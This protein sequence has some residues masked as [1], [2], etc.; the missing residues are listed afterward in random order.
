MHSNLLTNIYNLAFCT[1]TRWSFGVF[2]QQLID[3][4]DDA[5]DV[6]PALDNFLHEIRAF[7]CLWFAQTL[8]VQFLLD[9]RQIIRN[10][11]INSW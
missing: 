3:F 1:L 10:T 8:T 5:V 6:V 4:D 11:G 7:A 9:P 2:T